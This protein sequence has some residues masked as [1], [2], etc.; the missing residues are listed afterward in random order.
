MA[1]EMSDQQTQSEAAVQS[2][3]TGPINALSRTLSSVV[4][5][6]RELLARRRVDDTDTVSSGSAADLVALCNALLNHRGEASGLALA[7]EIV[8]GY[9]SLPREQ[10]MEFFVA[11]SRDF[12]VDREAVLAA[13]DQYRQSSKLEDL[14][15]INRAVEAPRQRLFRRINT[16]PGG[17]GTLVKMRGHLLESLRKK[18]ELRGVESD[19]KHLF[20]SWFNKGFLELRRIDWSSPASILEK[21]IAYEAVQRN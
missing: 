8:N 4:E 21:I 17:T 9:Q 2:G 5:V 12:E 13:A 6:G 18:P 10:R 19:L 7:S 3:G 16:A 14:W 15:S 20:V 11:L 1:D